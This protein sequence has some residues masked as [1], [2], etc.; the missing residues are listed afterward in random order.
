MSVSTPPLLYGGIR[1]T[2]IDL[3][4]LQAALARTNA[5]TEENT[6]AARAFSGANVTNTLDQTETQEQ[7]GSVV[8]T[9]T[10]T[11]NP[12]APP[13]GGIPQKFLDHYNYLQK[14]AT[15]ANIF[16]FLG[17]GE[18]ISAQTQRA[19]QT[20]YAHGSDA[21]GVNSTAD[22]SLTQLA[23]NLQTLSQSGIYTSFSALTGTLPILVAKE[24]EILVTADRITTEG[25][26][27]TA[28]IQGVAPITV[29]SPGTAEVLKSTNPFLTATGPATSS[30]DLNALLGGSGTYTPGVDTIL[31]SGKDKNGNS[32][33][34]VTFVYGQNTSGAQE[35]VSA[36]SKLVT[37]SGDATASTPLND[38][39]ANTTDYQTGNKINVTGKDFNGNNV[40][41]SFEYGTNGT[42]LGDLMNFVNGTGTGTNGNV[43]K[44]PGSTLSLT[45]G[46][47]AL[48][49]NTAGVTALAFALADD[50]STKTTW[51][52]F[53]ETTAG[54]NPVTNGSGTTLGA[55][56]T[57][58]SDAFSDATASLDSNGRIVLVADAIGAA[59]FSLSLKDDAGPATRGFENNPFIE[60][61]AGQDLVPGSILTG[62]STQTARSNMAHANNLLTQMA[63]HELVNNV[64]NTHTV[65]V[66]QIDPTA[67][68]VTAALTPRS[69]DILIRMNAATGDISK[70]SN[71]GTAIQ[72]QALIQRSE[73]G[74]DEG[75]TPTDGGGTSQNIATQT[76]SETE[77]TTVSETV[78]IQG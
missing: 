35:V 4:G 5:Q 12:P 73:G 70:V 61:T 56:V 43:D 8:V 49:A 28:Q 39:T 53:S 47:L 46:T 14:N 34:T 69:M 65:D 31:I 57:A 51:P 20:A 38:L 50:G 29:G 59:Q 66:R 9:N 68:T 44:F 24:R 72:S 36:A 30:T 23:N 10:V 42:T 27:S 11:V 7:E 75:G 52:A 37:A 1:T 19:G 74:V 26:V 58:I 60:T 15:A 32:I 41:A 78:E 6:Q 3:R 71:I 64:I 25:I 13:S 22:N 17:K 77:Q 62:A 76:A 2:L 63:T 21:A 18:A 45:A 33:P 67:P 16:D 55:L 48:Q 40:T 54:V